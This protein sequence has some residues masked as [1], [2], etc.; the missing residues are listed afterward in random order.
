MIEKQHWIQTQSAKKCGECAVFVKTFS[1]KDVT[2]AV[3]SIT[4]GGVYYAELNG[5]RIG[6][7]VMAP[8]YTEYQSRHQYQSY[9][10]TQL[11]LPGENHLAVTVAGGWYAGRIA[12]TGECWTPKMIAEITLAH[13]NGNQEMIGT[14][15]SWKVG[16]GPLLFSDIY[17]GEIYD[18]TQT[19]FAN[20]HAALDLQTPTDQL[21]YQEGEPVIEQERFPCG[22][23]FQTPKGETVIDFG[24][25]FAGYPELCVSACAGDEV[26]LSFAEI[27]DKDGNFYNENYR[28]AKCTYRYICRDGLQRYKPRC[29][30]YGFR[31]IRVDKFPKT[32][33]LDED[34]FTGIAVYSDIKR[35]GWLEST[36]SKLNSLFSN[37]FWGQRSNFLDIPTDCPQRDER[38]GWTGD[39]QVFGRTA[40]YNFNV[41]RF[42]KKWLRDMDAR[43]KKQGYVG[44]CI[45]ERWKGSNMAAGWSDVAVILPW[46]IYKSYGDRALLQE[47]SG[48]MAS[49]LE[50]IAQSSAYPNT[51]RGGDHLRQFGDWLATDSGETDKSGAFIHSGKSGATNADFLQAAFYGYDALLMAHTMDVLGQDSTSYY[52]LYENIKAQFHQDFPEYHTQTECAVA[53]RFGL[54]T[55][56]KETTKQLVRLIEEN[57]NR[58]STGFIGTPHLLHALSENGYTD[59]AYTL[60]LNEDFPS[61]LYQVNLGAT[62]MWEHW[63]GIDEKGEMW[64][65]EM[66]SFNHYAYGAVADWVYEV[67]AGIG[68]Q[69]DSA[70][71]EKPVIAP[72]PDRRVGG[73]SATLETGHGRIISKWSYTAEGRVRYEITVPTC[74]TIIIDGKARTV[75]KGSYIIVA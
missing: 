24:Q 28:S 23:I 27:L 14:D 15:T 5:K 25:N 33:T 34:T 11:L 41:H 10:I 36:N 56:R 44:Y 54:C 22:R 4:C 30:F 37:I 39:A 69:P 26:S 21:I 42:F 38:L 9:D 75:E 53:L 63:D 18:A 2:K 62:T 66:N 3:L 45:P 60:L 47:L 51:W 67:S 70:G 49:H 50:A 43:R 7:F 64:S 8:G 16:D 74:A 58:M 72:H 40:C 29:T 73:L 46:Q 71:F 17:D 35:T 68:Q 65:T 59:L 1:A 61:W 32:A 19:I 12:H 13:Q 57:G 31:Y 55:D 48:M 20:E 6:N 52:T